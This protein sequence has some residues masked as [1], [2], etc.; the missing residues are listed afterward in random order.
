MFARRLLLVVTL[1]APALA[2]AGDRLVVAVASNF[3]GTAKELATAFSAESAAEVRISVGSTGKLYGQ[4]VNGAPFDVFLAADV[5]RPALLEKTGRS[6]SGS[7]RTY[8]IGA[9][10]LWSR[11]PGLKDGCVDALASLDGRLAIANPAIA[12]YGRAAVEYLQ[13]SGLW[14][15]LE[16]SLVYGENASQTLQFVATGNARAGLVAAS[17]VINSELPAATCSWPVPQDMHGPIEQQAVVL[18]RSG[19]TELA[20]QFLDYLCSENGRE[21]IAAAGYRL[22]ECE[23]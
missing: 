14:H 12:P 2:A 3:A 9:L 17:H 18:A 20:L 13:A 8:A 4:I 11:D 16:P 22:P 15:K 10:V 21:I 23:S 5:E 7:R 1:L 19:N 6:V